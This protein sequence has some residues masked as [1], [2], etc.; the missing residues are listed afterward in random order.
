MLKN[1]FYLANDRLNDDQWKWIAKHLK[2]PGKTPDHQNDICNHG[3][4]KIIVLIYSIAWL[5]EILPTV[6]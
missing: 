6:Q 2:Y 5:S 4:K 1:I 3:N